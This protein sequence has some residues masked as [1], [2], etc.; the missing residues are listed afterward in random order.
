MAFSRPTL[1][2]SQQMMGE[3][4]QQQLMRSERHLFSTSD[5]NVIT[6]Q[7]Q[8]THAPDGRE[9]DVMPILHLLEDLFERANPTTTTTTVGA[10]I[11]AN[12]SQAQMDTLEDKTHQ[13]GFLNM[14][15]AL[16]YTIH[17]ISCEI[18]CK[19]SGG[20]DAHAV[21]QTLLNTLSSFSWDAKVVL[22]LAA[23]AVNYG[24]FWLVAQTYP[25]NHLAKSIA[26]LKHLPDILE[27][28]HDSLRPRFDA[29]KNLIKSMMDVTRCIVQFK[30][31]PAQY[32]TPDTSA[33]SIAIAHIP[34]AVYW[35]MRSVVACA[36][37]I[38]SLIGFNHEYMS[39]TTESWELSTLAH[40]LSNIHGHLTKQ[41]SICHQHIDEKR[42]VEAYKMLVRL[43]ETI[44]IDN[45]KILKALIYP[46][47]DLMPLFDGSNKRRVNLEVLRRKN[48]LLLISDH[49]MPHDELSILE[50]MY[51]ES[52][53]HPTR[54]ESQYEV[55]WIPIA[56]RATPWTEAK[57]KQFETLQMM[58]PWY[59]VYH[60]SLIDQAVIKY[61][62]EVWHFSKKPILVVLDPQGRVVCPNALHMLWIWGSLAF[63]FTSLREE[64]LWKEETWRLELL[65]DGIDPVII[66]WIAEG[67][68][69]CIY[70]GEDIEWIRKFT[71]TARAVAQAAR[72]PLELV[73]VGKSNPKERVRKNIATI[74][75][76]KLGHCWQDLTSI[77]FFWVRLESMWYSKM[78]L[79][80]TVENDSI[81]Q[82]I[83]SMMSFDGSDQ[84]WALFSRGTSEMA[85]G[86]GETILTSLTQFDAWK[87]DV[88]QKGF[89]NALKDHLLQIHPPHHCNRLILPGTAGRIP[90]MVVCAECGR[91]MEKFIMYRCCT[92]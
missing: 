15:E 85:K 19:C 50:Q 82:E 56:D 44:H 18:S 27:H 84:G 3:P 43:F 79:G 73:Y 47:D 59:T 38:T 52:R 78:Q 69:I 11:Q 58:M 22:T 23:F 5:D 16:A 24:E 39:S 88:E 76:E 53:Q 36:S 42:Q 6:K 35:T 60:P 28:S 89:I 64:A 14:L 20:G 32:I 30:A 54:L 61:I 2:S 68:F 48:V 10:V 80:K 83:M 45:M 8:A 12:G 4:T 92:D 26:I 55:V 87:G 34:T 70:G 49:E 67:R 41:L 17:K 75:F 40:K 37:Q 46:K 71:T 29:L 72:I 7:I 25:T 57:E 31:L 81:M 65:V 63:P 51:R 77:W 9:V 91:P 90:E 13:A 62:K 33:M 74:T 21:T 1:T 86:K 66:N